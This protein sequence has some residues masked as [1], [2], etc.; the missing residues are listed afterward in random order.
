M[1]KT[2]FFETVLLIGCEEPVPPMAAPA[3]S[4]YCAPDCVACSMVLWNT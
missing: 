2:L 3:P 4:V 1:W